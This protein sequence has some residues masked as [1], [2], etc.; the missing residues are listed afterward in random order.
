[1]FLTIGPLAAQRDSIPGDSATITPLVGS[2]PAV[3]YRWRTAG[4]KY[5]DPTS[6]FS[7]HGY[8]DGVFAG[9]SRD[10]TAAD[11]AGPGMPGQVLIPNTPHSSFQYDAA[12]F[13]A[14]EI[15]ERTRLMLEWHVV[16]DPSGSG[17]AGPGGITIVM[18]EA[19]A[20][21][22]LVPR[23]LT[24]T[25]G[26]F[27]APFATVNH[28]W[29]GAQNLFTV[30]PIGSGAFPAHLNERGVR[31]DGA[32][33]FGRNTAV[34]Y[35][36]SLGNG[37]QSFDISGQTAYDAN[38]DKTT[39]GRV[40]LFPGLGDRLEIGASASGGALRG[41]A[42]STR[43]IDDPLRYPARFR[44]LGLDASYH[45]GPLGIRGYWIGSRERFDRVAGS[46]PESLARRGAM[47]EASY[48]VRTGGLPFG[49]SRVVPKARLDRAGA[50]AL[51]PGAQGTTHFRS[52]VWSFG[53][54]VAPN[55]RMA[56]SFEYHVRRE[57]NRS[58]LANNRL[59]IRL[60]GEF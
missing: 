25:G 60:T 52:T 49:V 10:W 9:R 19:A 27:W 23:Y 21:W 5:L 4:G 39:I 20:S 3:S 44:A 53:A 22:D 58:P 13:I 59:V 43:S 24:V 15:S 17:A 18:T 7:L 26:L 14:S 54:T 12:V 30:V 33:Q 40:A 51:N 32:H 31:L 47:I 2:D 29:L 56:L 11:P 48:T 46:A 6:F 34:N 57:Q 16:S 42:D 55:D 41:S 50:D 37:T 36:L 35:V 38:E 8:V 1:M 28:D 45:H